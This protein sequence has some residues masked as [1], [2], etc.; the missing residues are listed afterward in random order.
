[1][2]D[3]GCRLTLHDNGIYS[4]TSENIGTPD[5]G[6]RF[7]F[8]QHTLAALVRLYLDLERSN[9]NLLIETPE[10]K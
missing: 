6:W 9:P 2:G 1:M 4:F 10:E 8:H 7:Q 5:S 3:Q